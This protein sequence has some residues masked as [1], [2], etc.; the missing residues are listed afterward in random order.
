MAQRKTTD[1][2]KIAGGA[3]RAGWIICAGGRIFLCDR[4][5]FHWSEVTD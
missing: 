5:E 4:G 1:L 3:V 2:D